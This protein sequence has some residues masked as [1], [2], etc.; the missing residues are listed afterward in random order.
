MTIYGIA[1]ICMDTDTLGGLQSKIAQL[2]SKIDTVQYEGK[3]W[4]VLDEDNDVF[5][6]W[7][8][9][10]HPNVISTVRA[11]SGIPPTSRLA[12]CFFTDCQM[13]A[14]ETEDDYTVEKLTT[15]AHERLKPWC[16]HDYIVTSST[17]IPAQ[18]IIGE[19]SEIP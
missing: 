5:I 10:F 6:R 13:A 1:L 16:S 8:I 4:V 7:L 3:E 15:K 18:E 9:I 17:T 14:G 2:Q 11:L 19:F 12:N